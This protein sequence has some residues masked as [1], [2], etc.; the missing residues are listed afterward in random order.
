MSLDR[1]I[2]SSNENGFLI[3]LDPAFGPRSDSAVDLA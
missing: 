2:S 3:M 1:A